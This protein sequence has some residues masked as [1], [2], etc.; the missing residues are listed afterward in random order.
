MPLEDL[1]IRVEK[2][3]PDKNFYFYQEK[4]NDII[5]KNESLLAEIQAEQKKE[6]QQMENF[7]RDNIESQR[8]YIRKGLLEPVHLIP[9]ERDILIE[10][11]Q[12]AMKKCLHEIDI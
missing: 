7:L 11:I 12:Y 9:K 6:W 3:F 4:Y 2:I 1:K 8:Y 5:S 10:G